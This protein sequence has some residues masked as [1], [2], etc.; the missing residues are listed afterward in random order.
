MTKTSVR[1][2]GLGAAIALGL[3]VTATLAGAGAAAPARTAVAHSAGGKRVSAGHLP[4]PKM[5]RLG[6]GAGEPTLGITRKGEI[7]VTASSGCVTSCAGSE[8]ALQTVAP[9]GRVIFKSKD[10]G[11]TWL[12]VTPGVP[13]AASTHAFSMDPYMFVDQTPDGSR[14]FDVDLTVA[15][16]ELSY[17]DDGG[18]SWTTSPVACGEPVNDHQTVFSG[19]PVTS[20]TVLYPKIIYY[21]FNHPAFTKCS[22]SLNGGLTF[23]PTTQIAN[24]SCSG[25]NGHGVTDS[26]GVVYIPLG[27]NSGCLLPKVAIS[28]DEG[29]TWQVIQVAKDMTTAGGDPSIAVDSQNNL[30][31]TWVDGDDRLP[32]MVVSRNG[33]K[34][35]SKPIMLGAPGVKG[36]NLVTMT[37]GSPGNVAFAYYG[38]TE[39]PADRQSRWSGYIASATG[40]L[41]KNPIFYSATVNPASQPLKVNGCGPGRCGRVLDFIDVEIAPDGQ[42][43]AVYVD[44]CKATCEK[45]GA[46]SIHDNEGIVGT[47]VGGPKLR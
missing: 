46:E 12:D 4:Q 41:G 3:L 26:K 14:V 39:D 45:T 29:N 22:K 6:H 18:A 47:L 9:G 19:K 11:K 28:K 27:G 35:W 7:F 1:T 15:C 8:E 23:V 36:T 43:W 24:P 38:T 30:Y 25:L 40:V 16:S 21:C 37:V 32:F 44:A 5:Y 2:R 31:Y 13:G 42:P 34:T 20:T 33:G 10:K 17:S